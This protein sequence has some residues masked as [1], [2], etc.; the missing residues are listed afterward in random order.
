M[1]LILTMSFLSVLTIA[2][3]NVNGLRDTTKRNLVY[4]LISRRK[5]DVVFIQETH[6]ELEDESRWKE[7]WNGEIIFSHGT[8]SSAGVA[9][10]T[11]AKSGFHLDQV[12]GDS[13]G[14]WIKGNIHWN[15][16]TFTLMSVYAPNASKLRV[17]FFHDLEKE[18]VSTDGQVLLGGDYNCN[19]DDDQGYDPSRKVLRTILQENDLA[20]VWASLYP[21][22]PGATHFHKGRNK[23]S[24]IDYMFVSSS[25]LH[26]CNGIEIAA[27]GLTDHYVINVKFFEKE[28]PHGQG[29]WICN[30]NLLENDD[31]N[32]R[33]C[34]FWS[35]WKTKK[36]DFPSLL[37][38]WEVAKYK[39]TEILR[40]FGREKSYENKRER[41]SLQKKHKE[42]VTKID[43]ESLEKLKDIEARIKDFEN[44]EYEK[45]QVRVRN[46]IKNEAE[47]PTKFFLTLE[48]QQVDNNKML[49][50]DKE[51]GECVD[52]TYDMIGVVNDFYQCLYRKGDI[53]DI[54]M[55]NII[56]EIH[57]VKFTDDERYDLE[58]DISDEEI[59][60]ALNQMK[61]NKSPGMD[62]LTVEFY[63]KFWPLIKD[64]FVDVIKECYKRGELSESMNLRLIRL[65]YK[66]RG[67]RSDLKNWRPI[68]LLNV[69][70]KILAKTITNRLKK[71]MPNLIS[72]EQTCGVPGRN[73]HDNLLLLR[74]SIDY[75]NW[76]N[77]EAA[78][79]SI[80][81]E[82]AFDRIDWDY[83][84]SVLGKMGI[85]PKFV[86]WIK[87]L[88][89]NPVSCVNFN[90]FIGIPFEI[91]RGIGQGCPLSPLLYAICAEGLGSLFRNNKN[92]HGICTPDGNDQV[93]LIQHADDTTVY[94]TNNNDF[95][96]VEE[97]LRTYSEGSGSKVNVNKTKGLWLGKWKSRQDKPC[98]FNWN[99]DQLKY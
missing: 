97:C 68:S 13:Y 28:K 37:Q 12:K 8:R 74:D 34:M 86:D 90:N 99:N 66:M 70:Y 56:N 51:E 40:D 17:D 35:F 78:I 33:I 9:I 24:R 60:R 79:L 62:G 61:R 23:V 55:Q 44:K 77:M 94:I 38:W 81:Q 54:Q 21:D 36:C 27:T 6:S 69:D 80:D 59:S 22:K 49:Y 92:L 76:N 29:R 87:L 1:N 31:C 52:N 47:K 41:E 3:I 48:N 11:S 85:P 14:R 58:K 25:L 18:I 2:S 50:I 7:N 89:S 83:M 96:V 93:K 43:E 72:E 91:S 32:K 67:S 45:S 63:R 5:F 20:D 57:N 39:I 46:I 26:M 53:S 88:Y 30:N 15:G 75:I 73:I 4:N 71:V 64:D 16:K 95:K 19:L 42:L 10:L 98:S 84:F 65:I 82:K